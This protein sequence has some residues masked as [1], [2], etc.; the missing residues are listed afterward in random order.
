MF[1]FILDISEYG[2][3]SC[4][5]YT[6]DQLIEGSLSSDKSLIAGSFNKFFTSA[7]TRL[8][9]S[10][11]SSCVSVANTIQLST[12]QYPNF[13]FEEVSEAFVK[14]LLRNLKRTKTVGLDDIPGRLLVDSA[15]VV[16]KPVCAIINK[17]G[18]VPTEWKAARV[19][20]L[21]KKGMREDIDNYR[22]ISILPAVSKVLERAVHHQLYAYL[23]RHKILSPF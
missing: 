1:Y 15:E 3:V 18:V 2:D 11:R 22:P 8:L 13:K 23:Q 16:A 20:P 17:S 12:R 10:A 5:Y 14:C 21:F 9:E 7:V 4:A 19:I 6:D